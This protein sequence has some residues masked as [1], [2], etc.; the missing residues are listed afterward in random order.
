MEQVREIAGRV[1]ASEGV[2]LVEVELHG[3]GPGAVLRIF[4]DKPGGI[5]IEDCQTVSRQ[6]GTLLD[7][8][9]VMTARYTLEVSSPG[10]DRKLIKPSDYD[11]FAGRK[12]KLLLR[13]SE[14]RRRSLQ[15]LLIGWDDGK[16][17]I[18]DESGATLAVAF[19]EIEK[20]NLVPE[21]GKKLGPKPESEKAHSR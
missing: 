16:V 6:V 19:D 7:I 3:R 5:S 9:G 10:L 14:G 15:G 8:E 17:R 13:N 11:R 21:F 12:V 2:E 4:L 1:A 18:E 20:A